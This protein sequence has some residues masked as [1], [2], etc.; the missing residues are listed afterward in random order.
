MICKRCGTDCP[1]REEGYC[2]HCL[3]AV[4]LEKL[5]GKSLKDMGVKEGFPDW[6]KP[7]RRRYGRR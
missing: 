2:L 1:E 5:M 6:K 4:N 7:N 3:V